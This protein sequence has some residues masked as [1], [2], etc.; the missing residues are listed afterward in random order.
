YEVLAHHYSR[1]ENPE[2]A[3]QYLKLSGDKAQ[4]SYSNW[5]AFRFYRN[6]IDVLNQLPQTEENR[7][8]GIEVRLWMEGPMKVLAYP[9]DSLQVLEEGE[10][11]SKEL[12]DDRSLATFYSSMGLCYAFRGDSLQGMKYAENCFEMAERI[13]DIELLAPIG[14][15]LCSSYAIT[16]DDLKIVEVAPRVLAL[17]EKTHRESIVLGG[18]FNFNLYSAL[19][20]YYGDAMG[21]LGNFEE[22]EAMCE[23]A[24]RFAHQI[25]NLYTMGFAEIMFAGLFFTKGDGKNTVE[26]SQNAIKYGEEGQIIPLLG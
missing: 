9:E 3:Y 1:S 23:K 6:A 10:R 22:G 14:F 12:G 26:H 25:D 19:S 13:Q 24:L 11:L 2:K 18:P 16:G 17:L 4:R 21:C 5:E 20:A 15:D 8:R 7:R